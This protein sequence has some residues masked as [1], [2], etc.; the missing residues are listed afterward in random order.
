M[1][2]KSI[3][4]TIITLALA[5]AGCGGSG[6]GMF[7]TG[8]QLGTAQNTVTNQ[9][10]ELNRCAAPVGVAA[11]VEP[12]AETLAQLQQIG[13]TSPVPVLKLLMARS[14]CFQIVDRGAASEALQREREL[15]AQGELQ[16]G[17]NMGGG[18]LVAAD[19]LI[20]PNIL[21][22]DPNAGGS[23]IGGILGG[24]LPG[25]LGAVA[26]SVRSTSLEAQVLLTLTNVRS[27]IQEAVA[28]GSATKRDIG[29]NVGALLIGGGV[30]AAGGGGSYT[31]TDIGKI[32]MVAFV[33]GLNKLVGQIGGP[34]G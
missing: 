16:E 2:R 34:T 26:G 33:D 31:N 27:G 25:M 5:I 20:T 12:G 9:A 4:I 17:S 8:T 24:L 29:F 3:L 22:Q 30:G 15:A 11:L 21:F 23:N 1:Y 6:G 18:Q 32:V 13:L 19:Y 10:T 7:N 28:E 14:N